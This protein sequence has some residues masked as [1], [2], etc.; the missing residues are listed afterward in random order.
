MK[1]LIKAG[2]TSV[3]EGYWRDPKSGTVFPAA[4]ASR[5]QRGREGKRNLQIISRL[6][7]KTVKRR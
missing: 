6:A 7:E 1:S 5:I 2:W 4:A 3:D